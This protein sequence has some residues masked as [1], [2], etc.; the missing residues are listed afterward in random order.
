MR[1]SEAR[2]PDFAQAHSMSG[3]FLLF[4]PYLASL[5]RFKLQF[6]EADKAV[7]DAYWHAA[8]RV[9]TAPWQA[10]P[11]PLLQELRAAGL[12]TKVRG[13]RATAADPEGFLHGS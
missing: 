1:G 12:P 9:T 11:S 5:L 7:L 10:L 13:S 6:V 2:A 3:K 8:Q 4:N